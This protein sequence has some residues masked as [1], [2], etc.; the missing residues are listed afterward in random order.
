MNGHCDDNP[1]RHRLGHTHTKRFVT[2][3]LPSNDTPRI[4]PQR[5]REYCS[6]INFPTI[7]ES[8]TYK[9]DY[10]TKINS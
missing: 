7:L 8:E 4:C 1:A 5:L 10:L 3:I 6:V 2:S 9:Y